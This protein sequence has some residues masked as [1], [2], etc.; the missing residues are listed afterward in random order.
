MRKPLPAHRADADG[1]K[2]TTDSFFE[3]VASCGSFFS[4]MPVYGREAKNVR[5]IIKK[6]NYWV[7]IVRLQ[8]S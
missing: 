1:S 6:L 3:G 7:K 8:A 4:Y 2:M 5:I